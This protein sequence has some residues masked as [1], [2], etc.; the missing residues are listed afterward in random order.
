[1]YNILGSRILYIRI[2]PSTSSTPTHP[3]GSAL[4]VETPLRHNTVE[5][6]AIRF[7]VSQT[8]DAADTFSSDRSHNHVLQRRFGDVL[9]LNRDAFRAEIAQKQSKF[10][11]P[12]FALPIAS[13]PVIISAVFTLFF[14]IIHLC[15]YFTRNTL[16]YGISIRKRT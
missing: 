5:F 8:A 3:G 16:S 6:T 1:M 4:M 14:F 9:A 15:I 10:Q 13:F 2:H 12:P 11:T 7:L